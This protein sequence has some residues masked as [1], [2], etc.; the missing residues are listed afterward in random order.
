[1]LA[2]SLKARRTASLKGR[3]FLCDRAPPVGT[4]TMNSPHPKLLI[5]ADPGLLIAGDSLGFCRAWPNQAEVTVAGRHYIQEDSPHQI[6]TAIRNWYEHLPRGLSP[7]RRA[8][9][10]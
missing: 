3:G 4:A 2:G 8:T 1:M 9:E 7:I 5:R 10:T 6:G